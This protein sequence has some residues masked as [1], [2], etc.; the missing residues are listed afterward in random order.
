M[1][2]LAAAAALIFIAIQNDNANVVRDRLDQYLIDYEPQLSSLIAD[3]LMTQRTELRMLVDSRR[4]ESEVAFIALPAQAGWMGF[5]RVV[6]VNGKTIKDRGVPLG[7]LMLEGASDDFDQ[8]RLLLADSAAY[9]LGAPRTIN[10]PNLPLE[11]LHPR[12]RHRFTQEIYSRREKIGGTQTVL[13]RFNEISAPTIIQMPNIGDMKS[14]VWAW[15]EPS[16]GRLLRAQVDTKDARLGGSPFVAEIRVD[17]RKD[18]KLGWLVPFEMSERFYV[19]RASTGSGTAKYSNYR[20]FETSAR[21][22][23]QQ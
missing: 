5:R 22:I 17:F 15:I 19:G 16:T 9:N 6:K 1:T 11:L 21:I 2:K 18:Q 3:E 8:A 20:R 7:Q 13:L 14:V 12:H 23:P 10:L 4:I